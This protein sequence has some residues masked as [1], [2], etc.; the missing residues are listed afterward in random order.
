MTL[1]KAIESFGKNF[2]SIPV[3]NI[4]YWDDLEMYLGDVI[5]SPEI[6]KLNAKK[7]KANYKNEIIKLVT[8][9]ILHLLGYNHRLKKDKVEMFMLQNKLLEEVWQRIS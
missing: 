2:V 3:E 5:I 6:A 1:E 4:R 7:Y 9:G 8:H